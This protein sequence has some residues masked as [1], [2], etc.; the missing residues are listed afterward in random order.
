L[1]LQKEFGN[2]PENPEDT[3]LDELGPAMQKTFNG[4][5]GK[6]S[7]SMIAR[8]ISSKMPGGFNITTGRNYLID[9]YRL[10]SR[11]QDRAFMLAMKMEPSARLRSEGDTKA[12]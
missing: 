4:Q 9:R 3:S 12:L 8:M 7:G 11:R 5:L 1:D 6:Q 10:Q 2:T